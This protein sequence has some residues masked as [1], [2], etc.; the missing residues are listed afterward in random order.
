MIVI[1]TFSSE[2][3]ETFDLIFA[4]RTISGFRP[5]VLMLRPCQIVQASIVKKL[6]ELSQ[7]VALIL[8]QL[9]VE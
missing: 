7:R 2:R 6:V 1:S 9:I 5:K 8:R 3:R 4:D